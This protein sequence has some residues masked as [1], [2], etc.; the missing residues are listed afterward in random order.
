MLVG[1]KGGSRGGGLAGGFEEDED[2]D[3]DVDDGV[4]FREVWRP[5]MQVGTLC[6]L[7]V[8]CIVLASL[9]SVPEVEYEGEGNSV[10]ARPSPHTNILA[11]YHAHRPA[12]SQ[13][14]HKSSM[15]GTFRGI[16]GIDYA[17]SINPAKN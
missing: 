13:P 10:H 6:A 1:G 2:V 7:G 11:L 5:T 17:L 4:A 9:A 8:E 12:S 15:E 14:S 16:K 3:V